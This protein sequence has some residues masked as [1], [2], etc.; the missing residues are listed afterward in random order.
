MLD[1]EKLA[2]VRVE[3][4]TMDHNK[5]TIDFAKIDT[6]LFLIRIQT[7]TAGQSDSL[8]IEVLRT[9]KLNKLFD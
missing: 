5:Y 7:W 1:Q 2:W 4:R 8:K 3:Q 9:D 6:D